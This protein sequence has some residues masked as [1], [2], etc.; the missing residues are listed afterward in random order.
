TTSHVSCVSRLVFLL[1]SLRPPRSTLLP[2]TTLFRSRGRAGTSGGADGATAGVGADGPGA[3]PCHRRLTRRPGGRGDRA[4]AVADPGSLLGAARLRSRADHRRAPRGVP[5]QGDARGEA[6]HHLDRAG[7]RVRAAGAGPGPRGPG[8]LGGL[9]DPGGVD[10]AHPGLA[11]LR[12][13]GAEAD[14]ADH[15][16]RAGRVPG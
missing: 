7:P 16:G 1:L 9:P 8:E 12:D 14:P 11:A 3:G 2:Y 5:E 4:A 6:P 15:A 13:S 10:P